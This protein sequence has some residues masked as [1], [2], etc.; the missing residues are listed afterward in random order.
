M[1]VDLGVGGFHG[2]EIFFFREW[3]Y[4]VYVCMYTC[5]FGG[6][7]IYIQYRGWAKQKQGIPRSDAINV[8]LPPR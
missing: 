5:E 7:R 6:C 3:K 8:K 4:G 1:S 2:R